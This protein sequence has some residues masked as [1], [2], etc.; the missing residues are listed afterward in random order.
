[1]S[2][3]LFKYVMS[4]YR[5]G[6]NKSNEDGVSP[7]MYAVKLGATWDGCVSHLL[8]DNLLELTSS[9][10]ETMLPILPFAASRK[11]PDI[12]MLYEFARRSPWMFND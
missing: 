9:E 3:E 2:A 12:S 6:T 1:M 8:K 7:L 4:R 10:S 5:A 11:D